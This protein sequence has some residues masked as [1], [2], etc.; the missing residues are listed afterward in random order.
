MSQP[1][2]Q[3]STNLGYVIAMGSQLGILIAFPMVL[4]IALGIWLD[5]K[6]NTFPWI[7]LASIFLGIGLTV[8]DVY[9]AII[10]FLEKRSDKNNKD[11]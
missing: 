5:R 1:Q 8:L 4:M 6:M 3:K 10:P 2:P 7:L 9:K 11:N